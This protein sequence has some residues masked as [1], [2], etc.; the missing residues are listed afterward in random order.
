MASYVK[1]E[2]FPKKPVERNK[3]LGVPFFVSLFFAFL[4]GS[5]Y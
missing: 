4:G 5:L 3:N 1:I 2:I